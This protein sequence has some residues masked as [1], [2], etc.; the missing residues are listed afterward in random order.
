LKIFLEVLTLEM[1]QFGCSFVFKIEVKFSLEWNFRAGDSHSMVSVQW[2]LNNCTWLEFFEMKH[3]VLNQESWLLQIKFLISTKTCMTLAPPTFFSKL[4]DR[5]PK[6]PE[7]WES[8]IEQN[9]EVPLKF[10]ERNKTSRA[11]STKFA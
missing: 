2:I 11:C 7:C 5:C 9:F 1:K 6:R 4:I 8:K 10:S 3:Y